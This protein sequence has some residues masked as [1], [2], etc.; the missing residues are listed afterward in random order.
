MKTFKLLIILS[1]LGFTAKAQVGV[2]TLDPDTT[3][4]LHIYSDNKGVLLPI[5]D[6][7]TRAPFV[8]AADGLLV[9]DS[10]DK[11]YYFFNR[12]TKKWLALNPFQTTEDANANGA[13]DDVRLG[14]RFVDRNVVI[15]RDSAD[16]DAKLHV[17]GNIKSNGTVC[18]DS[19]W[20]PKIGSDSIKTEFASI[21]AAQISTANIGAITNV[22]RADTILADTIY[23][24][25]IRANAVYGAVPIGTIVM[26]TGNLNSLDTACWEE[27]TELSGRFPVGAG[28]GSDIDSRTGTA[29]NYQA[30]SSIANNRSGEISV[31]LSENQMPSHTHGS[32]NGVSFVFASGTSK[33]D[34]GGTDR[35]LDEVSRRY[36]LNTG[37]AGGN[38]PHEN[39]PPFYG[40]YFIR[41]MSNNCPN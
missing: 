37:S 41:K 15:G 12:A 4:I 25:T 20:S 16:P 33:V 29:P 8:H 17:K 38:Q 39:R 34:N 7:N 26:W 13:S 18:A 3:A 24:T 9:Y 40:V 19:V 6:S 14:S 10:V 11:T 2:N 28:T 32:P 5:L 21:T 35:G 30:G 1:L 31:I 23:A 22:V 36:A 27:V